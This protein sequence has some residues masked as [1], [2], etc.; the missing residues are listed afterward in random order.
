MTS[1]GSG[2]MA[3]D[4]ELAAALKMSDD[5]LAA[6]VRVLEEPRDGGLGHG[7]ATVLACGRCRCE[8][9]C[10]ISHA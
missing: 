4:A 9:F 7:W 2:G 10:V 6:Q 3:Y 8:I 5:E 1:V